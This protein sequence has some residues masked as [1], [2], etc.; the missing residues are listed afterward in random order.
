MPTKKQNLRT[1][2]LTIF[3]VFSFSYNSR[4]VQIWLA[5]QDGQSARH[6]TTNLP[7][8]HTISLLVNE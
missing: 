3:Q 8:D 2:A 4:E 6:L 5:V 1:T 7:R